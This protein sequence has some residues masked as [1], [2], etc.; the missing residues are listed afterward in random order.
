MLQNTRLGSC[1]TVK[2]LNLSPLNRYFIEGSLDPKTWLGNQKT[3]LRTQPKVVFINFTR[4]TLNLPK[5]KCL[6][7]NI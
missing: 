4:D 5:E 1:V 6:D 7:L 2:M 3:T